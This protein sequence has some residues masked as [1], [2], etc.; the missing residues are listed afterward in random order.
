MQGGQGNSYLVEESF[1][2]H[3]WDNK[4]KT[5]RTAWNKKRYEGEANWIKKK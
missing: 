3:L 5:M 2:R 4:A 1:E